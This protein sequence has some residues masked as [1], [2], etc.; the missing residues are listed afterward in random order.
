M[1]AVVFDFDGTIADSLLGVLAVYKRFQTRNFP[2]TTDEVNDFRNKSIFRIARD[3]R[4]PLHHMIWLAIFGRRMFQSHL[5]K[6]HL[7]HGMKELLLQLHK[8]GVKIYILSTNRAETIHT[9][10]SQQGLS[11]VVENVYGKAFVFNKAPKLK[12]LLRIEKIQ[13]A[14]TACVG[15]ELLDIFSARRAGVQSIAVSWGY[16]SRDALEHAHPHA[17]VDTAAELKEVLLAQV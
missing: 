10:L 8:E 1:K 2:H 15:D 12:R 7:Y 14:E 3:L 6:V 16:T 9:F 17:L 5:D 4:I 11:G 13:R